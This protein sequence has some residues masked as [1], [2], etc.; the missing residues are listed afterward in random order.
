[1]GNAEG[2]TVLMKNNHF[3]YSLLGTLQQMR[4]S[5]HQN[6]VYVCVEIG[7][8]WGQSVGALSYMV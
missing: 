6:H 8:C 4:F 5:L 2:G 1:M 7:K 3:I